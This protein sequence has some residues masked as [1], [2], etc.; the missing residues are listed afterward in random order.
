ML[1]A[2]ET[3]AKT[4]ALEMSIHRRNPVAST[5]VAVNPQGVAGTL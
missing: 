4:M 5:T 3:F 1:S 2:D